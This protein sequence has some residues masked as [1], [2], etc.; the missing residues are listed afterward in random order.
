MTT[1]VSSSHFPYLKLKV[2]IGSTD[3]EQELEVEA[4]VD[5]GFSGGLAI[6][7][8]IIRP[9]ITPY[10]DM[11]WQLADET[12]VLTPAYLGSIQIGQLQTIPTSIIVLG[13]E[14]ILGQGIINRFK[15]IFDHGIKIT[16]EP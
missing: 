4:L 7:K 5:T 14:S 15:F 11:I 13:E 2:K 16:V 8:G 9:S 6:P 10:D 12:E 1:S 3:I